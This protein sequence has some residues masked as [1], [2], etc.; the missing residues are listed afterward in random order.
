M[1]FSSFIAIWIL[2]DFNHFMIEI[3]CIEFYFLVSWSFAFSPFIFQQYFHFSIFFITVFFPIFHLN[4]HLSIFSIF[5]I[6]FHFSFF[7][8]CFSSLLFVILYLWSC[9]C[10]ISS[11]F[12]MF[13]ICFVFSLCTQFLIS[14]QTFLIC[15][16]LCHCQNFV[17]YFN[18]ISF[19]FRFC[20]MFVFCIYFFIVFNTIFLFCIFCS[21]LFFI[22][23]SDKDMFYC[24]QCFFHDYVFSCSNVYAQSSP[25]SLL[26][27]LQRNTHRTNLCFDVVASW[28][29]RH[30]GRSRQDTHGTPVLSTLRRLWVAPS[31]KSSQRS[32]DT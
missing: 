26:T 20:F 11:F 30:T 7:R 19:L 23:F 9:I 32:Q 29:W 13:F 28:M 24:F 16:F 21:F 27:E 10:C 15:S 3:R 6:F 18:S 2:Q 31:Q 4:F 1:H 12:F 8:R 5:Y 25:R 14:F 22:S 17:H